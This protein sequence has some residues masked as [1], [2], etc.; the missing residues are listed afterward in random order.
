[1]IKLFSMVLTVF[2]ALTIGV[3]QANDAAEG[4][5]KSLVCVACHGAVGVSEHMNWPNLAGQNSGY[6][7]KQLRDFRAGTRSDPWMSPI[8]YGLSESD[9]DDLAEYYANLP[10]TT[11]NDDASTA[12]PKEAVCIACHGRN[13]VIEHDVW[14][15]LAGQKKLY[16]IEHMNRFRSGKRVDPLMTPI[17]ETLSESDIQELAEYYS[18]VSSVND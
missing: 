10:Q 4:R 16:L 9:I 5:D 1:M 8:A 17:A 6:I 3:A 11:L 13:G 2:A 18:S 12:N 15:N 14:P 7:A